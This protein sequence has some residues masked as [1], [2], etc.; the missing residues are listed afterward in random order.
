M[1]LLIMAAGMGSRYG[2]LKQMDPVGPNGEFIVDFSVYDAMRAGFD[3]VVFIIKKE[4]Y[5]DFEQ[6]VGK[7]VRGMIKVEYVFQDTC[8]IPA[9]TSVPA[10]RLKPLGTGHAV[11]CARNVID[12]P[13]AVI[14]ADDFYGREAFEK[15][16]EYLRAPEAH[17]YVMAG[18]L[19][20]NTI[21][22][23]G[24]V[25]RG[26]CAAR[27]GRLTHIVERTHIEQRP[28]GIAFL[29]DDI[30]TPLAPD[31]VVSMNC[32]GFT[33]D[34]FPAL[35]RGLTDFLRKDLPKNPEKAEFFLPFLVEEEMRRGNCT[36]DV[37]TTEAK[38]Y[39]VTYAE[40]RPMMVEFLRRATA[41]GVYP[42]RLGRTS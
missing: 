37:L 19:L 22:E 27:D 29:E 21:T 18:Y 40:D 25:S 4:N 11:W 1:T 24:Y 8:D 42:P 31:T 16:G 10:G 6:T 35:E 34:L 3:R 41:E 13:F 32:W 2:G 14:N 9:G 30:W 39:G 38:W 7:R 15:L 23:N 36:V 12:D 5:E 17:R 20:K 33:P 28:Q 26:V